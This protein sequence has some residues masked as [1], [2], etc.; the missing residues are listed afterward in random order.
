MI[1]RGTQ[2][3]LLHLLPGWAATIGFALLGPSVTARGLPPIL[4]LLPLVSVCVLA[5][6][7]WYY[8][9]TKAAMRSTTPEDSRPLPNR[10]ERNTTARTK[11]VVG[12]LCALWAAA[13]FMLLGPV[14]GEPLKNAW[15]PHFPSVFV[16]LGSYVH[17]PG[18]YP[19]AIRIA[20]WFA[21]FLVSGLAAPIIEELYFRQALFARMSRWGLWAPVV[22]AVLFALYH[23][24]APWLIPVRIVAVLPYIYATYKF[25]DVRLAIGVHLALN[26]VGDVLLMAPLAWAP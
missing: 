20:A 15:A 22:S 6:E 26:L 25:Q 24:W 19:R 11:W 10:H 2:T 7:L 16:Q 21:M 3:I 8:L 1:V 12:L 9:R 13:C 17:G 14:V 4:A 23:G 18:N 5:F